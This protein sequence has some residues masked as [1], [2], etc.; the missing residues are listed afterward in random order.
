[1]LFRS[2]ATN[3]YPAMAGVYAPWWWDIRVTDDIPVANSS[4]ER[5]AT[6][7]D[8]D[9]F[10][11]GTR[12]QLK[13]PGMISGQE[14]GQESAFKEWDICIIRWLYG[15]GYGIPYPNEFRDDDGTCSSIVSDQCVKDMEQAAVKAYTHA[16]L[17]CQC[18]NVTE[19]SSCDQDSIFAKLDCSANCKSLSSCHLLAHRPPVDSDIL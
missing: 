9:K 19:L 15:E 1:M 10:F 18:P 13:T 5:L 4:S 11:T 8:K 17:H 16:P 14:M 12:V 3:A 6:G 7:D 2:N